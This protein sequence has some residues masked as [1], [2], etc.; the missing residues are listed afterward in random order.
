MPFDSMPQGDP[1][2]D[3]W[4]RICQSCKNPIGRNEPVEELTFAPDEK[5]RLEALNGPYHAACA[6][7]YLSIKRALDALSRG[8]F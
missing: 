2:G 4:A 1:W 6:K 8:F 5:H 3:P 7:P